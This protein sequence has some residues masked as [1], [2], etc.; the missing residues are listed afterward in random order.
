MCAGG[1]HILTSRME[2]SPAE[3]AED[4]APA[5]D[6]DALRIAMKQA[7]AAMAEEENPGVIPEDIG[8]NDV[9]ILRRGDEEISVKW[10]KAK[11]L[12][13]SGEG[14][15]FFGRARVG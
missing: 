11:D 5:V 9:V 6:A 14:W 1:A 2:E 12:L 7:Q 10:K 8:R 13:E 3:A 15:T 4:S